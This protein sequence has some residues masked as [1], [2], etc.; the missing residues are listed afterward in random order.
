MDGVNA[1]A[2]LLCCRYIL[3]RC[4][5]IVFV[6]HHAHMSTKHSRKCASDVIL[7]WNLNELA[8]SVRQQAMFTHQVHAW[9]IRMKIGSLYLNRNCTNTTLCKGRKKIAHTHTHTRS[10]T[11]TLE[12]SRIKETQQ[13]HGWKRHHVCV[14]L[15]RERDGKWECS[16]KDRKHNTFSDVSLYEV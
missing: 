5:R 7:E 6:W 1:Y 13:L 12:T 4:S 10:H 11:L 2:Y 9:E 8:W 3:A 16:S 15:L 14:C